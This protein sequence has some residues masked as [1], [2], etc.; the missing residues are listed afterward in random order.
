MQGKTICNSHPRK[1]MGGSPELKISISKL[2]FKYLSNFTG[3][4][5]MT[6]VKAVLKPP[7]AAADG[8]S[9]PVH[10]R[11]KVRTLNQSQEQV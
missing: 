4:I 7:W 6:E 9:D 2:A 3:A 1:L 11:V 8:V 5:H 10:R